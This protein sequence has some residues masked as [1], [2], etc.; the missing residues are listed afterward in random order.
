[1]YPFNN[2]HPHVLN[3]LLSIYC[4][5][6]LNFNLKSFLQILRYIYILY[7]IVLC[8][9]FIINIW[10]KFI[11]PFDTLE[12]FSNII[13]KLLTQCALCSFFFFFYTQIGLLNAIFSFLYVGLIY[14]HQIM[15]FLTSSY[16]SFL[17][18][19]YY[20]HAYQEGKSG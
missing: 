8:F 7:Y 1:M 3:T 18:Y 4:S 20:T 15:C 9:I 6:Y 10:V 14:S 5:L 16:F 19:I 11:E 13:K 2:S 17:L 12:C